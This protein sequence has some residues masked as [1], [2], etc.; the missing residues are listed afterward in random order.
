L[1]A[2]APKESESVSGLFPE[3]PA[4]FPP[5]RGNLELAIQA[6]LTN[7]FQYGF[8]VMILE[9]ISALWDHDT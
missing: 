6:E 4:L 1:A 5:A 3:S 2:A 9:V 8:L 7:L